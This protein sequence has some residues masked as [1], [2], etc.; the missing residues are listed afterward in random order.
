MLLSELRNLSGWR[1]NVTAL[2]AGAMLGLGLPPIDF[3]WLAFVS[4]PVLFLLSR[5][6]T[7]GRGFTI[8]WFAGLGYFALT[9][10]WIIEPF[11]VD[12]AAHGWM[13]PFALI[14]L[15]AGLSL[16][17]ALAFG[18][19]SRFGS[20]GF[21]GIVL[22]AGFWTLLEFG[23]S[24]LLTGFPWALTPYVWGETPIIQLLAFF[25]PHG[26]SFI[27]LLV[28]LGPVSVIGR[29]LAC[30]AISLFVFGT[31]WFGLQARI[32]DN[33]IVLDKTIRLVQPNAQQHE[34][35]LPEKMQK[36]FDRQLE[37]TS[38]G[39]DVDLI[40]WPEVSVPYLIDQRMDLNLA[41]ASSAKNNSQVVIGGRRIEG[42][43]EGERWFNSVAVLA[44]DGSIDALYDKQ[45]LV[46]FGE[47]LPVADLF[48]KF[49][50]KAL[51]QNAGRFSA[52]KSA[53]PIGIDGLPSFRVLVCY[54]AIFPH[55]IVS[56]EER[57][58][59]LL[60]L[61]NDAWFGSFSGPFQHFAQARFR[62][63]EQGLPL[64][65]AANTG[66]SAMIDPFGRVTGSIEL[67]TDGFIDAPIPKSI[68]PTLYG[69]FGDA[70]FMV[71]IVLL[72]GFIVTTRRRIAQSSKDLV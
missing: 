47:Y 27:A 33:T 50:L 68:P 53:E 72:M 71:A 61:T 7:F 64:A 9:L 36:F 28:L 45:H 57:P 52:G 63:I 55:E 59:L 2:F 5:Q 4:I 25:G 15:A 58:E 67:N 66:V 31:L 18:L 62:A 16:F 48:D 69:R 17:W 60:H 6:T 49:G 12:V 37:A 24:T 10:N 56:G 34:K 19:F 41:I 40:V 13:A 51:A 3:P 43:E 42:T 38:A 29:P 39:G 22:F 23:R 30:S 21:S 65:R 8:G 54:E 14:F 46:P 11:L 26:L 1:A 35:W 44:K 70:P 20:E 32:P